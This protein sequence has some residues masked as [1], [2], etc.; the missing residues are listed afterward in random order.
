MSLP[1]ITIPITT[2]ISLAGN[3]I[4][5]NLIC[6]KE[7]SLLSVSESFACGAFAGLVSFPI[8]CPVDLIKKKLQ[9]QVDVSKQAYYKSSID[10]IKKTIKDKGYKSLYKGGV[11]MMIWELVGYS[12][13]FGFYQTIKLYLAEKAKIPYNDLNSAYIFLAGAFAGLASLQLTYPI[14]TINALIQTEQN[15][16][17]NELTKTQASIYYQIKIC[18]ETSEPKYIYHQQYKDG[19]LI[20]CSKYIYNMQGIRGFYKG[21]LPSSVS[22]FY[23][24]GLMFISFEGIMGLCNSYLKL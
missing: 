13:Y 4:A 15:F 17:S 10:C 8:D 19:G 16:S 24:S 3:E 2:S 20:S 14:S 18:S 5:K 21:A 22:M 23:M 6:N 12:T 1:I 9:L 11:T 7:D